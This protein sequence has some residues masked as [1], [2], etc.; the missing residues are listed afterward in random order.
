MEKLCENRAATQL[1]AEMIRKGK[2]PHSIVICGERGLGKKTI[3]KTVAAQLL[4]ERGDGEPCGVCR[5][6]RLISSDAHPDLITA[7]ASET[8]NYKVD[9][10]RALAAEAFVSPSEGRYKVILIPDLDRSAQTLAQVQ[11]TLLKVVEEPPDSA[12]IILTARSKEIFLDTIISR[13]LQLQAEEVSPAGAQGYLTEHGA[14]EKIAEEA[15]RKCGGNI[16][17]C[18]KYAADEKTRKLAASAEKA[19]EALA[20]HNEYALLKAFSECG[21]KKDD[22]SA[23]IV[24]LQRAVRDACRMRVGAESPRVFSQ[25]ACRALS[26]A[27]SSARLADIYDTLGDCLSRLSANCLPAV[28]TNALSAKLSEIVQI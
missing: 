19:A 4:C 18:L 21:G 13:T 3:A 17:E 10:I 8:G 24:F 1:T 5:S 14:D 2:E 9:D 16:G 23:A 7:A 12:V 27:Y 11:N 28:V 22:L 15:V 25:S 20:A 6:C 26:V